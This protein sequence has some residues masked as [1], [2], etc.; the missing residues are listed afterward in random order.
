MRARCSNVLA[1]VRVDHQVDVALAVARLDVGE[2]VVEVGQRA[3]ARREQDELLDPQRQ[4]AAAARDRLTG[5]ADDI[6]E[7]GV[8][9]R[10]EELLADLVL[11]REQLQPAAAVLEIDERPLA[12]H[13]PAHRAPGQPVALTR[14]IARSEIAVRAAH[15]CDLAAIGEAVGKLV[16]RA[17]LAH[18]TPGRR[19]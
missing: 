15:G 9:E 7:L 16:E 18:V 4:L 17:A 2:T 19:C 3:V 10:R 8:A 6:A 1:H 5:D 14:R 12:V 13:A 11:A